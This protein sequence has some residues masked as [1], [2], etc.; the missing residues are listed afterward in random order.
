[1]SVRR[2]LFVSFLAIAAMLA[3]SAWAWSVLP[4][5]ARIV[6]H[7]NLEFRP[8]SYA[9][10]SFGLLFL[11][12]LALIIS[13]LFAIIPS[14]EPRRANLMTSRKLYYAGWYGA[15]GLFGTIH[16]LTVLNAA[17]VALDVPRIV[18][19]AT[20]LLMIVLGNFL[21]KS[22]SNFFVGLRLPWTLSSELA[23]GK[24]NR[25]S[26]LGMMATGAGALVLLFLSSET[27]AI[28]VFVGG[29]LLTFA[30]STV[31]AFVYWRQDAHRSQTGSASDE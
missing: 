22:R 8:D 31:A 26:G 24:A 17:G 18:L 14:I 20:A 2:P 5:T 7:W 25:L 3:F 19:A 27:L 29:L 1:M 11:P 9:P 30:V 21:G 12:G 6:V 15:L 28:G 23:W 10:K 13:A 16:I 4:P